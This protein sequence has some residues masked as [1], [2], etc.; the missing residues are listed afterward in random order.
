MQPA[1]DIHLLELLK[2]AVL[3]NS[4]HLNDDGVVGQPTEAALLVCARKAGVADLR[5]QY[6][7]L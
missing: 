7:S 4:A 6:P 1:E 2:A 5:A 3:C